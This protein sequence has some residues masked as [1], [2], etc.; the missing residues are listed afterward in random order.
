[1]FQQH[2]FI[3]TQQNSHNGCRSQNHSDR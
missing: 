2:E 1:L 3:V